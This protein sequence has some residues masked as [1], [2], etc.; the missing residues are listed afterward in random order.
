M[1][2]ECQSAKLLPN[3]NQREALS[4]GA[5]TGASPRRSAPPQ[6]EARL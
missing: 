5:E 4:S 3:G 6:A 2:K 1:P